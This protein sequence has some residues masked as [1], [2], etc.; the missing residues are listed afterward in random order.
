MG[1]NVA[2]H[3]PLLSAQLS[4]KAHHAPIH[5]GDAGQFYISAGVSS[6]DF[7]AVFGNWCALLEH[8]IP[9]F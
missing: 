9:F 3:L 5:T 8:Y 7:G 6:S 4:A 1:Q 2:L